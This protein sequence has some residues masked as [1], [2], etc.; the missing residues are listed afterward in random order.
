MLFFSPFKRLAKLES[1]L[2]LGTVLLTATTLGLAGPPSDLVELFGLKFAV[3]DMFSSW[4]YLGLEVLL[5]TSL[6][7]CSI[8]DQLFVLKCQNNVTKNPRRVNV[9]AWND[10]TQES[11]F[12]SRANK[13]A[14][15]ISS[16][17]CHILQKGMSRELAPLGTHALITSILTYSAL[18]ALYSFEG[19]VGL[20]RGEG[21][22]LSEL[23]APVT[24]SVH[25]RPL[26]YGRVNDSW[27]LTTP[28]QPFVD[29]S[30]LSMRGEEYGRIT[31]T[32]PSKA[33]NISDEGI[34]LDG[35]LSLLN[36]TPQ[37]VRLVENHTYREIPALAI[38]QDN[39]TS[40][41]APAEGNEV[42]VGRDGGFMVLSGQPKPGSWE[43]QDL[44]E[45]L[46]TNPKE[47]F[48]VEVLPEVKVT[49]SS[50]QLTVEIFLFPLLI[51]MALL[52]VSPRDVSL[53]L[54]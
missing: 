49:W 27:A 34:P 31:V 50:N 47:R 12:L 6:V 23:K 45:L 54:D 53:C 48:L 14:T 52:L 20:S 9:R 19:S 3:G 40:W 43:Q 21:L 38:K 33:A 35:G 39:P 22:F 30:F 2:V 8:L 7:A 42:L 1:S 24:S 26:A 25:T 15:K 4:W 28:Y 41:L 32:T 16:A 29:I 36:S 17:C 44:S 51:L 46:E 5:T 10:P 37:R 11:V 18:C 13:G